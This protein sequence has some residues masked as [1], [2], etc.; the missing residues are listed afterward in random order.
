VDQ[1][2]RSG[3]PQT[4]VARRRIWPGT[5]IALAG[6][7]AA[8]L[9][10]APA[11]AGDGDLDLGF[12]S[13]GIYRLDLG[14]NE[15][16]TGVFAMPDGTLF[17]VGRS[18]DTPVVVSLLADG[19]PNLEYGDDGVAVVDGI[20]TFEYVAATMDPGG[21]ALIL[22]RGTS[23]IAV[24]RLTTVGEIDTTFAGDGRAELPPEQTQVYD[25]DVDAAGR[26]VTIGN[27]AGVTQVSRLTA[28]GDPDV[29]FGTAGTVPIADLV[30]ADDAYGAVMA[31]GGIAVA[32]TSFDG[33][34]SSIEVRRVTAAGQVDG[35]FVDAAVATPHDSIAED[36][37][38]A[39][40]G[41]IVVVGIAAA[42]G[43]GPR[44][45]VARFLA[46]GAADRSFG[47]TGVVTIAQQEPLYG[48]EVAVD[49]VNRVTVAGFIQ[50][51]ESSEVGAVTRLLANGTP[52]SSFGAD[53][54]SRIDIGEGLEQFFSLLVQNDGRTVAVGAVHGITYRDV[55]VVRLEGSVPVASF[56]DDDGSVF[57]SDIEALGRAGIT[58]GC[59]PPDNDRFCPDQPVTRGQMAAFLVR[60]LGY[61]DTGTGDRF[62]DDNDSIFETD[63]NRLATAGITRGCNPPDND[64]FCPDQPVT[65][66]QMAAFLVRGLGLG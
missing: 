32:I 50:P 57:E 40:S 56:V 60:G 54:T 41:R 26:I 19:S 34:A 22:G 1:G 5:T 52:D 37:A 12:S 21:R 63:I 58:R 13:E 36:V 62:Q 9:V 11:L 27:A 8:L 59:N 43:D 18:G 42:D 35:E 29:S 65:R 15:A 53:G 30:D 6:L 10:A 66:G 25:I 3:S 28:G 24:V 20:G 14:D 31:D 39:P 38:I 55:F 47:Q 2:N 33:A 46:S 17:G 44:S 45:V 16:L 61:T 7:L 64:R 4:S 23:G 49:R 51:A 48:L